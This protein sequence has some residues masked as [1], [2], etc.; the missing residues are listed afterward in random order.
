MTNNARVGGILS[1]VAGGLGAIGALVGLLFA[2]LVGV[3]GGGRYYGYDGYYGASGDWPM[4]FA[5]FIGVWSFIGLVLSILA[6]IGGS[7]GIRKKSWGLALMGAI[8]SVLTFFPCG[9]AAIVFTVM[10]RLEFPQNAPTA[11]PAAPTIPKV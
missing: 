11:P 9:V 1:I 4:V 7:Y 3:F 8:A 2:I 6:I 10:G 5:V